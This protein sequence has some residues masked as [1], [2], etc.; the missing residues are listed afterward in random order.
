MTN[1]FDKLNLRPFERRLVVVVG[2]AL[3][4]ILN[5]FLVWPYFGAVAEKNARRE[6]AK[7]T[8]ALRLDEIAQTNKFVKELK[9]LEGEGLA[10]P[11]EDQAT[12]LART[13]N[14][15]AAQNLVTPQSLSRPF[16]RTNEFFLEQ[17]V[18]ITTLSTEDA[19]VNFLH[20]LGTGTS[21]IRVRE[22]TLKRD[23]SQQKLTATIQLVAS[24]QKKPAVRPPTPPAPAA[25]VAKP[26]PVV[27][28]PATPASPAKTNSL[29]VVPKTGAPK[30]PIP[31]RKTP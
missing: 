18:T 10:V 25:P 24:Y 15:Q 19:L 16:T 30:S 7:T 22:L 31:P 4:I 14:Y 2:I 9:A 29:P 1:L 11:P 26:A 23:Q 5:Y 27:T 13:I 3:F 6:K 28:K 8:L 17:S 12:D 21:L 20:S